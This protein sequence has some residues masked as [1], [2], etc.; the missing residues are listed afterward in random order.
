ML[1]KSLHV[2][3]PDFEQAT[4]WQIKPEGACKGDV[5]IPLTKQPTARI[6]IEQ[7]AADMDLP[8]AAEPDHG[9]WALGPDSIGGRALTT[10]EAPNLTLPDLDGNLFE[11]SSLKGQKILVYAWAPY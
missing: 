5:C 7:L 2:S 4:G 9:I 1:L 6:D 10:A 8:L 11:L 3:V